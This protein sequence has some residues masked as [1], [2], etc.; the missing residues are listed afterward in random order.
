[1][2]RRRFKRW[3]ESR[4]LKDGVGVAGALSSRVGR[5]FCNLR[6]NHNFLLLGGTPVERCAA[7]ASVNSLLSKTHT[8]AATHVCTQA[9]ICHYEHTNAYT[10]ICKD[11]QWY[12]CVCVCVSVCVCVYACKCL[13]RSRTRLSHTITAFI[14]WASL[15][16][17]LV[18]RPKRYL[19]SRS[20]ASLVGAIPP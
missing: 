5:G 17:C 4:V 2:S 13:L 12:A 18:W 15:V 6:L 20:D 16:Q 8:H 9:C 11:I 7:H 3:N 19:L 1:M 14:L 10:G